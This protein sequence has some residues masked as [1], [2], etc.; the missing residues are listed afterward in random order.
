MRA[1]EEKRNKHAKHFKMKALG[2]I[3]VKD[4]IKNVLSGLRLKKVSVKGYSL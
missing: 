4:C 1:T 2:V 3:L